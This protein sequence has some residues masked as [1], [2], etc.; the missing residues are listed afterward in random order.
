[1]GPR[2]LICRYRLA[3]Q[4][5]LIDCRTAFDNDTVDRDVFT[6]TNQKNISDLYLINVY[7]NLFAVPQKICSLRRKLHQGLQGVGRTAFGIGFECLA[8]RDQRQDHACRLE[9]KLVHVRRRRGA[10]AV[11]LRR[12]HCEQ[13]YTRV[14]KCRSRTKRNRRVHVR[15]SVEETAET[16]NKEF[17]VDYHNDAGQ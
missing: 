14:G 8:D 16:G 9:V 2:F 5:R 3:G 17:L 6:R 7:R 13:H 11:H 4:C 12:C 15:R 1:M 10:S